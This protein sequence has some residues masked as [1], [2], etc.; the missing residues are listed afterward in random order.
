MVNRPVVQGR[1]TIAANSCLR[2]GGENG[3]EDEMRVLAIVDDTADVRQMVRVLLERWGAT[4]DTEAASIAEAVE[5]LDPSGDGVVVLDHNLDGN[6]S[7]LEGAPLLRARAPLARIVLFSAQEL[8]DEAERNPSIDAFV[9]KDRVLELPR[10]VRDLAH[11]SGSQRPIPELHVVRHERETPPPSSSGTEDDLLAS[12][13]VTPSP[14]FDELPPPVEAAEVTRHLVSPGPDRSDALLRFVAAAGD[15]DRAV[16]HLLALRRHLA[17]R[18]GAGDADLLDLLIVEVTSNVIGAARRAAM[19]DSLTG[20]GNRRALE[21]DLASALA[22]S[23]RMQQTLT[24]V[25]FDLVGLKQLNDRFGHDDGDRALRA[26]AHALDVSKRTGD[27]CYRVGGDEFVALMPDTTSGDVAPF[28]DR[29]VA[30]GA[31]AFSWGAADTDDT[32]YDGA[33]LVRLADIR[34]LGQRYGRASVDDGVAND[35]VDPLLR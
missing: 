10:V 22:R 25:Y 9:R 24:I 6:V 17:G 27:G 7:G 26:F 34:L 32:G 14:F 15:I 20:I 16:A 8:A 31:P 21:G 1:P 2:G 11:R 33:R 3:G 5:R 18:S 28:I 29:L 30:A 35:P 13:L 12:W 23:E 19:V 4:V